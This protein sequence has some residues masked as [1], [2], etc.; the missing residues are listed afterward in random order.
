MIRAHRGPAPERGEGELLFSSARLW[1]LTR[2]RGGRELTVLAPHLGGEVHAQAWIPE[3]PEPV[4]PHVDLWLNPPPGGFG[5]RLPAL[6]YPLDELLFGQLLARGLGLIVHSTAVRVRGRGLLFPGTSGVGKSTLSQVLIDASDRGKMQEEESGIAG[7][8]VL[9]DDRNVVRIIDG[10]PWVFG[11][12]WHGDVDKVAGGGAPLERILFLEH[13]EKNRFRAIGGAEAAA[14]LM[15][16]SF[17]PY[18][19]PE[20]LDQAAELVERIV[21]LCPPMRFGFVPDRGVV[22]ALGLEEG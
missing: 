14:T 16:R 3:G 15:A 9:S 13:A 5:D 10:V 11:T 20:Q 22:G 12:P 17:P 19:D 21:E 1:R 2:G 18:W 8:E 4:P 6:D 7:L